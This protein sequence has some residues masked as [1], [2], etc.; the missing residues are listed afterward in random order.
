M[1]RIDP[2]MRIRLPQDVKAFIASQAAYNAS[3]LS[4]EVVRCIRERMEK[5]KK[6]M[7]AATNEA[8]AA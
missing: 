8:Q 3:S 5:M 2:Q 6:K 7:E 4:S 1:A